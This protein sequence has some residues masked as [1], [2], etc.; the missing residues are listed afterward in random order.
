MPALLRTEVSISMAETVLESDARP[1]PGE[2]DVVVMHLLA[3]G[4][5]ELSQTLEESRT[6]PVPYPAALQRG[7]DRLTAI[8]AVVGVEPPRSAMDLAGWA[9][10][11]FGSWPWRPRVDGMGEDERLLVAGK[12]TKT[13]LEWAVVS[14]DVEGEVRERLLVHGVLDVCKAHGRPDVYTAFRRMLVERPAMSE[15]DLAL[16]LTD[17][18]LALVAPFVRSAYRPAPAETLSGGEA[19]VCGGCG[20]LWVL[21]ETGRRR[22]QEWDCPNP[23]AEGFRLPAVEGVVWLSRELRMFVSGP[24]RVELRIAQK[25]ERAGL[26]VALWPDF[27]ACDVFPVEVPWAADV[28]SWLNPVRLAWRLNEHPFSLP[29]GAERGFIV[30][31]TEQTRGRPEYLRALRAHCTWLKGQSRVRAVTEKVYVDQVIRRARTG[32]AP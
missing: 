12:P 23:T 24:G 30:I 22:C 8:C 6:F 21:D 32:V 3:T 15:R 1:W 28:K 19:V 18:D 31:A 10:R 20:H 2:W 29:P 5:V 27:D 11:P 7:L 16:A 4:L 9:H 14:G 13:C 25:L 17:P 26:T